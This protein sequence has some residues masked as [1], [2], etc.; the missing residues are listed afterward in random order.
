MNSLLLKRNSKILWNY[1]L[2]VDIPGSVW[3]LNSMCWLRSSNKFTRCIS[4]TRSPHPF[5]HITYSTHLHI[6][7]HPSTADA[8]SNVILW[9]WQYNI[10]LH[11]TYSHTVDKKCRIML[12]VSVC[13]SIYNVHKPCNTY[14]TTTWH[15]SRLNWVCCNSAT[16]SGISVWW[17]CL[18]QMWCVVPDPYSLSLWMKNSFSECAAP[19][20]C[21][22][23]WSH[24]LNTPKSNPIRNSKEPDE[25]FCSLILQARWLSTSVKALKRKHFR[26]MNKSCK[27]KI[28][29]NFTEPKGLK[30][31]IFGPRG[32]R[33]ICSPNIWPELCVHDIN[34]S[35]RTFISALGN[36]CQNCRQSQA[37]FPSF[38]KLC[39]ECLK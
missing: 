26:Q 30:S 18:K 17:R 33:S 10:Q 3:K 4:F 13:K 21:G 24:G 9:L 7:T 16:S 5:T 32:S 19:K 31:L 23:D 25:D 1:Q 6:L 12:Q 35:S 22:P 27:S 11:N 34:F 14:T 38:L 20:L 39:W 28:G 36:F 37:L 15:I 8:L 2:F 29:A